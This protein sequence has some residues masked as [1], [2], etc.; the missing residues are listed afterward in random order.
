MIG[1]LW[2]WLP[3]GLVYSVLVTAMTTGGAL[4]GAL[5]MSLFAGGQLE[6]VVAGGRKGG[7]KPPMRPPRR[8]WS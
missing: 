4:R 7:F 1:L 5:V 8:L 2:G 3:C 6:F